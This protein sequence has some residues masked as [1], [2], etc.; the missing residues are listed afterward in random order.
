MH[1]QNNRQAAKKEDQNTQRNESI[2]GYDV[3]VDKGSP[4]ANG[5]EPHEDCQV[6]KH[7]DGGLERVVHGFQAEP[8]AV[9][10]SV[11]GSPDM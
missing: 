10:F 8:V 6:E 9:S 5:T 2:D 1:G 3:V 7:V 4:G 11:F